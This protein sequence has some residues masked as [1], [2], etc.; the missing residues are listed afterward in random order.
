M[1]ERTGIIMPQVAD[2][3]YTLDMIKHR[4]NE[5]NQL[6]LEDMV[7]LVGNYV[8]PWTQRVY[9]G[10]ESWDTAAAN[11]IGDENTPHYGELNHPQ[12]LPDKY[13]P[14]RLQMV[15][16][17]R[18]A[19]EF[20]DLE[21]VEEQNG[22]PVL[23]G[24]WL[25]ADIC[26]LSTP[27]GDQLREHLESGGKVRFG[28]RAMTSNNWQDHIEVAKLAVIVTFDALIKD[29]ETDLKIARSRAETIRLQQEEAKA[30]IEDE[31]LSEA[32]E[33]ESAD[34]EAEI[35]DTPEQ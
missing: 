23:P 15:E 33:E 13:D 1:K 12:Q 20:L 34:A 19:V 3:A 22:Q 31:A 17:E 4:Y 6:I 32:I 28:L 26:V 24:K 14:D 7:L 25:V 18:I 5:N 11:F 10:G 9:P 29:Y 30:G 21:V 8:S 16:P 35:D 27:C 2:S